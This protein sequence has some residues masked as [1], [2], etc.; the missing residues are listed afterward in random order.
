MLLSFLRICYL[1][2]PHRTTRRNRQRTNVQPKHVVPSLRYHDQPTFLS[3]LSLPFFVSLHSLS[4]RHHLHH[5]LPST[6]NPC[7]GLIE[8]ARCSLKG[9]GTRESKTYDRAQKGNF[10]SHGTVGVG[11]REV[12]ASTS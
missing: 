1:C 9:K 4:T 10:P 6:P 3:L 8:H 2:A 12:G 5:L 11:R 7:F